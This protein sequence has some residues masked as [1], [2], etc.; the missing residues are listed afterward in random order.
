MKFLKMC[1]TLLILTYQKHAF[2]ALLLTRFENRYEKFK[3]KIVVKKNCCKCKT[4]LG[5]F[6][7]LP[8]LLQCFIV[9]V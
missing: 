4:Q 5:M 9:S 3:F 2:T 8:A 7:D 1:W 6:I